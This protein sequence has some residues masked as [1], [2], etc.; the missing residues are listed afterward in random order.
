MNVAKIITLIVFVF[1]IFA[2]KNDLEI[3]AP[4]EETPVVY[5]LLDPN[6]NVQF[7]RIQKTYQNDINISTQQGALITDSLYF[8]TLVVLVKGSDGSINNFTKIDTVIKQP[9]LF[10]NDKHFLYRSNMELNSSLNY[11]LQ[12]FSP[13][14]G[15]TYTATTRIIDK[16][17]INISPIQYRPQS[18][19]L[20]I[21]QSFNPRNAPFYDIIL[22]FNYKEY[23]I[24]NPTDSTI[25][26]I[27]YFFDRNWV[28][29]SAEKR[30]TVNARTWRA[31]I[32]KSLFPNNNVQREYVSCEFLAVGASRDLY[33][34]YSVT[35]PSPSVV[36]KRTEYSNIPGALGIF[37]SRSIS[38]AF[39]PLRVLPTDGGFDST[40]Y[41]IVTGLPNF[42]F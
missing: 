30:N 31:F 1:T 26:S 32:F 3:N 17:T 14:S 2:C 41:L 40:R 29:N 13:K 36:Q 11:T 27:D 4:W 8:D 7:I 10:G 38:K 18:I 42:I 6:T 37:S 21:S 22:R 34:A 16:S 19:N 24:S 33:N 5:G 39:V 23:P 35:I 15:K 20:T 25:K 28:P 9:G 12:I